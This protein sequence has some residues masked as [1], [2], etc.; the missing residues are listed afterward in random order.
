MD[1]KIK[2]KNLWGKSFVIPLIK[3]FLL[4]ETFLKMKS[5]PWTSWTRALIKPKKSSIVSNDV[6]KK[7]DAL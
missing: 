7:R 6:I 4:I 1:E 2:E 5:F 3:F